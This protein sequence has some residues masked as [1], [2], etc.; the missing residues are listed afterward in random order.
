VERNS[1]SRTIFQGSED[2][3]SLKNQK[4]PDQFLYGRPYLIEVRK[5]DLHW[6]NEVT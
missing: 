2:K 1:N 4:A 3:A 6:N 5:T